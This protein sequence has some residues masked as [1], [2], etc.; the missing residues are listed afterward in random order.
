[1]SECILASFTK[2]SFVTSK[3]AYWNKE[4]TLPYGAAVCSDT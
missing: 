1:M 2:H 4:T 3:L